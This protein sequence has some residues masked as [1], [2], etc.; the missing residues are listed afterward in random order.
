M[1][2]QILVDKSQTSLQRILWRDDSKGD[3]KTYELLTMTYDTTLASFL[4]TKIIHQL[5]D[6]EENQFPVGA[7]TARWN[8]Y[9][10]DLTHANSIEE[11]RGI[12][13]QVT[14]SF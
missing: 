9:L 3:I 8:F 10:D 6:L 7:A 5:A 2:R 12:R 4:A 1:Y 11:A 13:D 14:A